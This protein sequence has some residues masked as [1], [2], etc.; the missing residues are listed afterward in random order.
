MRGGIVF[1]VTVGL[2]AAG[3]G[4]ESTASNRTTTSEP[5]PCLPGSASP[6]SERTLV[7][8]F[9]AQGIQLHRDDNCAPDALL[10]LSNTAVPTYE[11]EVRVREAEGDIF[12]DVYPTKIWG[13]RI[14]R[15][16]WRNDPDPTYV[17][18]LNVSC[19]HYPEDGVQTDKLEQA[20]RKL[21]GVS[22]QPTTVPSS[23]AVHD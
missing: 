8:T 6:V 18:V 3:C 17:N 15:F 5:K 7:S 22:S 2:V 14:E 11:Q 21:P 16:V 1:V 10:A 13:G 9:R 4:K 20:F 12:C 19:A 23:D